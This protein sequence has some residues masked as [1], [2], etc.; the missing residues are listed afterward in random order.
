ML[1]KFPSRPSAARNL[2]MSVKVGGD[3]LF[4]HV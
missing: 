1:L 4:D 2:S 3:L